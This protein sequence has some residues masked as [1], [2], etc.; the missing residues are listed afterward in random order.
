MTVQF[1]VKTR[2]AAVPMCTKWHHLHANPV[3]FCLYVKTNMIF[4]KII[5]THSVITLKHQVN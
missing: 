5:P 1:Q 2:I 3:H 4:V